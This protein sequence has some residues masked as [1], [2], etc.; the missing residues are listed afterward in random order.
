MIYDG[1]KIHFTDLALGLSREAMKRQ[2]FGEDFM[3]VPDV[4]AE[5]LSTNKKRG[6]FR[7]KSHRHFGSTEL[8]ALQEFELTTAHYA[9]AT[10]IQKAA[11]NLLRKVRN[12]KKLA[13]QNNT[14]EN[15]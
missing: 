8:D 3:N 1:G 7:G 4:I 9:A 5:K 2:A 10:L 6:I 12:R 15:E 13:L 14:E 11:R